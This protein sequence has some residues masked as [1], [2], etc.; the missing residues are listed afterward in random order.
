MFWKNLGVLRY[1]EITSLFPED[2][3]ATF[4]YFKHGN[5]VALIIFYETNFRLK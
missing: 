4:D 3:L 5:H 2:I 1:L